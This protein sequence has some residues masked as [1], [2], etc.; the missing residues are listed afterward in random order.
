MQKYDNLFERNAKNGSFYLQSKVH[1]AKECLET[2]HK[3]KDQGTASWI[4]GEDASLFVCIVNQMNYVT[5]RTSIHVV[6]CL[7]NKFYEHLV[8][9]TVWIWSSNTARVCV[10]IDDFVDEVLHCILWDMEFI[11]L[12][13]HVNL[14]NKFYAGEGLRYASLVCCK[15]ISLNGLIGIIVL[16]IWK[17]MLR[18]KSYWIVIIGL[19]GVRFGRRVCFGWSDYLSNW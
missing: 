17:K 2:V 15:F 16:E 14:L 5:A 19:D 9:Y 12:V 1:R 7:S 10:L 6:W 4:N 11:V 8:E 13:L 18:W 3:P